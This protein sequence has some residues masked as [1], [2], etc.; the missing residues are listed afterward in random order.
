MWIK[1]VEGEKEDVFIVAYKCIKYLLKNKQEN[2]FFASWEG[3]WVVEK[4]RWKTDFILSFEPDEYILSTTKAINTYIL[5]KGS[6]F[7]LSRSS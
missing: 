1:K 4:Q 6:F 5:E 7:P 2:I 3:D